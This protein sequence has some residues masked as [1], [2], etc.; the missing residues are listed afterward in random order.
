MAG[1]QTSTYGRIA[2]VDRGQRRQDAVFSEGGEAAPVR[3]HLG[4]QDRQHTG[5]GMAVGED[6][7]ETA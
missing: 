4:E 1:F 3:R 7:A 6:N 5:I 2:G